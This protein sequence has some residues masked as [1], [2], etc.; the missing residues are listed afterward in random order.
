METIS[1]KARYR[2][3]VDALFVDHGVLR[4]VWTNFHV[5]KPHVLY[6]SNHPTPANLRRFV[7]RFGIKTLINLRGR[8]TTGADTLSREA[9]RKLGL[10]FLDMPFRSSVAPQREA[11]LQLAEAYKNMRKPA[12]VHCKS[13][14][15]RAGFAAAIFLLVEGA[16]PATAKSQL[17]LRYGHLKYARA[18]ILDKF[19]DAWAS[20]T[21]G[22]PFLTWVA[23]DYDAAALQA[24][25]KSN[26]IARF[27]NDRI[28][29]RE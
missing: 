25:F 27:L 6:R 13:G 28:L 12:L 3:W 17:A 7:R 24:S 19:I 21:G 29:R 14:A 10:D 11:I 1:A 2:T 20:H 26:A 15:D 22:K 9:A 8:T 4:I 5:V 18:G 16:S 23:Q